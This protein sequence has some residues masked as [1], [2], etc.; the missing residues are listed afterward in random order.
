M[1]TLGNKLTLNSQPIYHFVN[2]YSIDFDG[3]DQC[4]TTD[5]ADTVL[6]NTTYSFWSKSS[7]TGANNGVF[8]HGSGARGSFHFN[9]GDKPLLE[10]GGSSYRWWNDTSA[11]DDGEWHH[12]VVYLDTDITKSKLYCDGVLQSVD[13]TVSSGSANAYTESLTIGGDKASGGNYFEGKMSQVGIF[14]S[15]LT[16]DE[17]SSLYNHG[18]PI[19]LSTDQAAYESSSNLVG[20]W[21]MGS[22]TLDSYPLIADQ[23]DATL[24]SEIVTGDN[25][26]FDT[27][28]GDWQQ[29]RGVLSWDSSIKAGKWTDNNTAGGPVGFTMSGGVIPTSANSVYIIEFQ[30]KSDTSSAINFGYIGE[31]DSFGTI[32]NPNLTNS[33]QDYKFIFVTTSAN[34]RL[35]VAF[36]S[37]PFADGESYYIDNVSIKEV[38]G[39]PA[40]MT[41]MASTD[42]ENGSPTITTG[43]QGYWKMGSGTND[44]FPVIYDQ[45]D[46]TNG[47]ELVTNGDF[48]TDSDW[49]KGTG[50]TISNNKANFNTT[51]N[52]TIQ[53]NLS[54]TTGRTYKIQITGEITSGRLKLS[55]SSGLGDDSEITLPLDTYY[56]HDGGTNDIQ[57]RTIGASIGYLDNISI[58]EVGGNPATMTNMV[59][60]NI[61]NQYPLTKIRNYW[62]MGDGI[63]DGYPIIQDQTSP[64]LAHIPTTNFITYSEDFSNAAWTK[65][66]S[67]ISSNAITSPDGTQ[68]ADNLLDIATTDFHGLYQSHDLDADDIVTTSIFVKYN[69]KQYMSFLTNNNGASDRYAYFDLINKTTHSLS[70]GITAYIE[71]YAND[72]LRLSVTSTTAGN[73]AY[74]W[75]NIALSSSTT[76]YAGDG[77]GSIYIWGSQLEKQTQDTAYLKS[78]GVASVRKATT[79]NL[80]TYSEDLSQY[81]TSTNGVTIDSTSNLSPIGT[82][83]AYEVTG[84]GQGKLQTINKTLLTDTTYTFSFYAKNVDATSVQSRIY[85]D[86]SGGSNMTTVNYIDDINTT[87]WARITHTFTTGSSTTN[88]YLYITNALIGTIQLWGAQLEQQTQAETYAKTTGL[89]VTID[90]FTENNYGTMTNMVAGDIV[91]DTP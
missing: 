26:T 3:A 62:R 7:Q 24:G 9:H 60:G 21:R 85:Y 15:E 78:D 43:L 39:N 27:S 28:T 86:G 58:K 83:N 38:Q 48:A 79:T 59:E 19:D 23:T 63:L 69:N 45:V 29:F 33:F 70:S 17:V 74:Y 11:Q 16:A 57:I 64:N 72:W 61:T 12:W 36:L 20:Y 8:G 5:G 35:Y 67:T 18:L 30:A 34:Q 42:I 49:T 54:I 40:I 65:S 91:E 55:A 47:S 6:Q 87:A 89:P 22:G 52:A 66:A 46:P 71:T 73:N 90:L 82:S 84:T 2:K 75:W 1:L 10:L 51:G 76:S 37:S 81:F 41:N 25:S 80:I 31:T 13:S 88:Y 68:N 53:Q 77:T 4:I 14:N 44:E 50:W 56:T 32:L